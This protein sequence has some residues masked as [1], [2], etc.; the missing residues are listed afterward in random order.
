MFYHCLDSSTSHD[1]AFTAYSE[2]VHS[3]VLYKHVKHPSQYKA[4]WDW[5]TGKFWKMYLGENIELKLKI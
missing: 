5:I 3:S 1:G 2:D 4:V